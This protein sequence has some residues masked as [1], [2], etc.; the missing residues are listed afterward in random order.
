MQIDQYYRRECR[1]DLRK[2]ANWVYNKG[3]NSHRWGKDGLFNR[4]FE[5]TS[6]WVRKTKTKAYLDSYFIPHTSNTFPNGPFQKAISIKKTIF[7]IS[8]VR[9]AFSV[10]HNPEE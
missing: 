5:I 8:G 10:W 6:Y 3:S 7:M 9:K 4:C 1:K 2:Y